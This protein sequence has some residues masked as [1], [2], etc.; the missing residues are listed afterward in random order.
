MKNMVIIRTAAGL[1]ALGGS[2]LFAGCGLDNAGPPTLTAPSEFGLSVTLTATPDQLPRDN[3]SQSTITVTVRDAQNRPVSG[4][5]LAV[6][7]NIGTVSQS[8]VVTAQDGRATFTF[9]APSITSVGD[10]T[11]QVVPV[12]TNASNAVPRTVSILLSPSN[13]G[14]PVPS[15]TVSPAAPERLQRVTL[16]AS[17]TTDDG[18]ACGDACTYT[19]DFGG[20][21]TAT[22]RI[23]TYQFQQVRTY[24]V[25]LTV[26]D[27]NGSTATTSQSVAVANTS[28]PTASFTFSPS[29]PGVLQTVNFDAS[30]SSAA[31]GH[32]ISRFVWNFGDGDADRTTSPRTTHAFVRA[33][34]FVVTLTV[35]DEVGRETTT[36]TNV[37][38]VAGITAAF[39]ISPSNPQRNDTVNFNGSGSTTTA[40]ANITK[41][42]WDFGD[43]GTAEST[44][45]ASTT[46]A[47]T[48]GG[49]RTYTV[50]LTI[51]DSLGR[52]ATTTNTV[53]VTG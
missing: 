26:R 43:G 1:V 47:Y 36:T 2:L 18:V 42:S 28:A 5:R 16:D 51:T 53:T 22:G 21:A 10:A 7:A 11:I 38:V 25:T 37:T 4:Q 19:W 8:E 35:Q 49:G 31:A 24:V 41:Y 14:A 12:G 6:G 27:Q 33:G 29:S 34:T 32:S 40:G 48:V 20:E 15:F 13:R 52:T 30:A 17:A 46:H 45:S 23:V 44:S 39:T 9:T 3:R 50:R